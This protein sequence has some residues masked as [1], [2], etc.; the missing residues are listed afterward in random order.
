MNITWKSILPIVYAAVL[1]A[2]R[3]FAHKYDIQD[4]HISAL[5]VLLLIVC[6]FSWFD[7]FFN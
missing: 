3:V 7:C 5:C 4:P 6:T 1:V 2:V